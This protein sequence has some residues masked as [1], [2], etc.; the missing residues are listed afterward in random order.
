M[1]TQENQNELQFSQMICKY[2]SQKHPESSGEACF[3][4]SFD[5][6]GVKQGTAALGLI[7]SGCEVVAWQ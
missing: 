3:H 7:K 2:D 5:G 4:W 1:Y 6:T